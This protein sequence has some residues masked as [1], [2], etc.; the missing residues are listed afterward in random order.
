MNQR[1]L[2]IDTDFLLALILP[3]EANYLKAIQ[4]WQKSNFGTIFVL[5]LVKYEA[6]NVLSRKL[7][8]AGA[9]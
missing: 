1:N 4:I 5:N 8:Q 2:I 3:E 9:I 7:A 6:L